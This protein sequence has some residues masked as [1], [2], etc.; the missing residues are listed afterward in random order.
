MYYDKKQVFLKTIEEVKI[1]GEIL[2]EGFNNSEKEID[3]KGFANYVTNTDLKVQEYLIENLQKII[4]G[5]RFVAEEKDNSKVDK[6]GPVW[7]I[8]PIDGTTN[9]IH[10]YPHVA[11]SLALVDNYEKIFG[12]VYNPISDELFYA[13]K[14]EG[15]FLNGNKIC[16]SKNN[17]LESCIVGFGVPYDRNKSE[18]VLKTAQKVVVTCEDLKRCGPAS[19]DI[20]YVACGRLDAYFELN[21]RPWDISAGIIIL[22]EAKGF[23]TDWNGRE[24]DLFK[25]QNNIAVTNKYIHNEL[26]NIIKDK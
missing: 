6:N 22:E 15:A 26:V 19:L 13:L 17:K 4:Q 10:K 2:L 11:I 25:D 14:G 8:D 12:I 5:S 9:F 1:A 21:L 7:I 23:A 24:L 18:Y 3:K 16:A 20:C